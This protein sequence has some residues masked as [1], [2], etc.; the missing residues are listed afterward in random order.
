[1]V[2]LLLCVEGCIAIGGVLLK[3]DVSAEIFAEKCILLIPFYNG[4]LRVQNT[5]LRSV[6]RQKLKKER[7]MKQC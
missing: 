3:F 5:L 6:A 7:L 4:L 1:M 2:Q